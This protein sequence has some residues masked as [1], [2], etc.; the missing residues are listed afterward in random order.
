MEIIFL[1]Q[2]RSNWLYFASNYLP[3][4]LL[5][6]HGSLL[7][8]E[9]EPGKFSATGMEL[10]CDTNSTRK[11]T[12]HIHTYQQDIHAINSRMSDNLNQS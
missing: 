4:R 2:L 6:G 12:A 5:R 1:N 3:I 9:G 10:S 7:G 11:V 8:V